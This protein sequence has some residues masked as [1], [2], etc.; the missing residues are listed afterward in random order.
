MTAARGR[1]NNFDALRIAAALMV[2]HG[3]GWVLSGSTGPG[4]WGVPFARVGL[5]VFFSISGYLVT[6]SWERTPDLGAFLAKRTRRILPGLAACVLVMAFVLGP[7]ATTLAP[8]AYFAAD[9]TWRYLANIGLYNQLY[10]PGVFG[11]LREY[12]AVNGSLWSLLPEAACYLTVPA[13]AALAGSVRSRMV[14][15]AALAGVAGG[16][17]LFLF[18][19]YAGP[20]YV[21]YGLDLKYGLVEAPFFLVGALLA[22]APVAPAA[23]WRADLALLA[24]MLNFAVSSWIGAWSLPLQWVATPYLVLAA[25]NMSMPVLRDAGRFGDLSFGLYLYAFPIQQVVLLAFP[26]LHYPVLACVGLTAVAAFCSWHLVE[27][28]PLRR[29]A[30]PDA[31]VAQ[32]AV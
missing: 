30:V 19:G 25:A 18:T 15:L 2:V 22:L 3:H 13:V 27:K 6:R 23:L 16:V 10:L 21:A 14:L 4:L 24:F 8:S 1:S 32:P 20:A 26:T 9:A 31:A 5:D 17:G 11:G 28:R 29:G 7:L 12:G